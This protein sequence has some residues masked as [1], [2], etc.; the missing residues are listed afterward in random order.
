VRE[1]ADGLPESAESAQLG[2]TARISLLNYGWRLG[3]SL[4]E[5]EAMF[6]EAEALAVEAGDTRSRAFIL[7]MWGVILGASGG[8]LREYGRIAARAL[9]L[10]GESGDPGLPVAMVA[11]SYAY[12]LTGQYAENMAAVDRA[13]ALADGDP[14]VGAG[15]P[16]GCPY[17][18]AL[19]WKGFLNVDLGDL[20]EARRLIEQ[21]RKV[22]GDHGDIEVAGWTHMWSVM[23]AYYAGETESALPHAQQAVDIAERMGGSFSRAHAWTWFGVAEQMR[24]EWQRSIDAIERGSELAR[25]GRTAVE[26]EAWRLALLAKSY[27]GLGDPQRALALVEQAVAMAEA[28]GQEQARADIQLA[29]ARVLLGSPGPVPVE[30]VEAALARTLAVA[31]GRNGKIF[32]PFVH[33]ERAELARQTGDDEGHQRELREAYRLFGECGATGHCERLELELA[34]LAT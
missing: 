16:L 12:W 3:I 18:W 22:A 10:A 34:L 32:E 17:A 13:I 21:A 33:A 9:E 24:G 6:H 19:G 23:R 27:L 20:N 14:T 15:M 7:S 4:A 25:E 5:A 30:Q 1:L 26:S 8:D 31:R 2:L 28:Q 29:L 11:T